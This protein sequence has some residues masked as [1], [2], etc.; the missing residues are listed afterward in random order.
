MEETHERGQGKATG[1]HSI[2]TNELVK[3]YSTIENGAC[4]TLYSCV[5]SFFN[6]FVFH[7]KLGTTNKHRDWSNDVSS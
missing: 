7:A 4:G 3:V 2:I 6:F 1:I 5:Y